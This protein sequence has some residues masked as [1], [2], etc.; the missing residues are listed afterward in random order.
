MALFACHFSIS[1]FQTIL[2][3]SIGSALQIAIFSHYFL[4]QSDTAAYL[5][6]SLY[7]I[8]TSITAFAMTVLSNNPEEIKKDESASQAAEIKTSLS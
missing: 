8:V 6:I 2:M 7:I 3:M 1:K 4:N 5:F